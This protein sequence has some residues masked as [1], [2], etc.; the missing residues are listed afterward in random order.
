MSP[1]DHDKLKQRRAG[2][3][4][5]GWRPKGGENLVRV[6]PPH[7]KYLTNWEELENLAIGYRI[8]F[9]R[10]E[11]RPTEVS[12]CLEE[13]N[14]RCPACDTWR[15][16]RK[17]DDPGL[18]ELARQVAPADQYLFNIIDVNDQQA[19]I[20]RWA[21]NWTCWDKI[22]EIAANP[23]WGNVVDPAD[24]IN[25]LVNMTPANQSR[26]G[27]N[28]YSVMPQPARTQ[29]TDTLEAIPDW[30][31]SLDELEAQISTAKDAAEIK[32]LLDEMGFPSTGGGGPPS[33]GG[34][35][36]VVPPPTAPAPGTSPVPAATPGTSPVP[37]ATPAPAAA[38]V[39][40]P[41][42]SVTPAPAAPNPGAA[43]VAA[44]APAGVI[45]PHYDPG[46]EYT[47]KVADADRP[48]GVPRCFGDYAPQMHRCAPCPAVS[49][50]QM[51]MLGV[52]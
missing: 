23:A 41:G 15:V 8:H 27:F 45:T 9:F 43:G 37:A 38:S 6:L 36:A 17:S 29:V 25:F 42:A 32:S 21:S 44:T 5:T 11:G 4:T 19:G 33:G 24:G 28:Q 2:A 20:Q 39:S 34:T 47:P 50:C 7:S 49:D 26:T 40:V 52:L 22:M 16:H 51:K 35:P 46:P 3:R 30:Q 1:L 48:V 31:A 12:R 18:K 14:Q 10:V 13:I